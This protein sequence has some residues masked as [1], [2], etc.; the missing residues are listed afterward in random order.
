MF[1]YQVICNVSFTKRFFE[2]F[3][4]KN[5]LIE[6]LHVVYMHWV[7]FLNYYSLIVNILKIDLNNFETIHQHMFQLK[8]LRVHAFFMYNF[9]H[10]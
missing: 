2:P 6:N 1:L 9:Y 8:F 4:Y 10:I 7:F 5:L 3:L